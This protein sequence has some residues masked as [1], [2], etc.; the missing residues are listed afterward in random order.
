MNEQLEAVL[1]GL[2]SRDADIRL[3]TAKAI[4]SA[5]ISYAITEETAS[6]V[7]GTLRRTLR[8]EEDRE[9]RETIVDALGFAMFL[10]INDFNGLKRLKA[11]SI[12]RVLKQA[13]D[14]DTDAEIRRNA[15]ALL[16]YHDARVGKDRRQL[17]LFEVDVRQSI[18]DMERL[19]NRRAPNVLAGAPKRAPIRAMA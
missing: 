16:E 11:S 13:R 4:E 10:K 7:I 3:A 12:I 19:G 2:K 14:N 1:E 6:R 5:I 9:V 18:I 15:N 8:R 17:S